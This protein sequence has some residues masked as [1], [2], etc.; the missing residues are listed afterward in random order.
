M[1]QITLQVRLLLFIKKQVMKNFYMNLMI[2]PVILLFGRQVFIQM[3]KQAG[4][5][6]LLM[7]LMDREFDLSIPIVHCSLLDMQDLVHMW[8]E[9]LASLILQIDILTLK[10]EFMINLTVFICSQ[11]IK[12]LYLLLLLLFII[13]QQ[14]F[15][16]SGIH[17][18]QID[19]SFSGVYILA[20]LKIILDQ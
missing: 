9:L 3:I 4:F 5:V 1:I 14:I 6:P 17:V 18:L 2:N 11:L 8:V 15:I 19:L 20:Y 12:T 10:K 16:L 7:E 13:L